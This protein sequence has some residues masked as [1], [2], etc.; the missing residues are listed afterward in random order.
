MKKSVLIVFTV[1]ALGVLFFSSCNDDTTAPNLYWY[2]SAGDIVPT[3]DTTVLLYTKYVDPG[4]YVED[5][6]SSESGITV[7]NDLEDILSFTDEG[8]VRRAGDFV[9][10]YNATDEAGNAAPYLRNIGVKNIAEPFVNSYATTRNTMHLPE[11]TYNSSVTADARIP[12][13]L[14][15][16]KVYAHEWDEQK[17]YFRV[18]ADLY[19]PENLSKNFSE[20][21]GYMGTVSDKETPFFANMTYETGADS[22]LSFTMLRI[23]AQEYSDT[24]NSHT[25]YIQ[26]VTDQ[27]TDYPL[28][29]IEYLANSKTITRIVLELNVTKNGVVDRVTEIYIP[30][31]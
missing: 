27:V 26:G 13:R 15:F 11:T 17:T 18:N 8:Y 16:P 24:A 14:R 21:I 10:T 29:R 25:V 5:N 20:T 7:V 4:V 28:S 2:N 22:I 3:G 6:S 12:G 9:V 23:D 30:N 31:D 1:F 19:D